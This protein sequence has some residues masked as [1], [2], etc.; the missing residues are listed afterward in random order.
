[1]KTLNRVELAALSG[2]VTAIRTNDL[3]KFIQKLSAGTTFHGMSYEDKANY[4]YPTPK[5]VKANYH[6]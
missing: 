6:E 4:G 1:M 3:Y 5:H 2:S